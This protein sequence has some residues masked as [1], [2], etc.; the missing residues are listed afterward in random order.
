MDIAAG[1]VGFIG[2]SGQI[3]QGCNYLCKTFSDAADAPDVIVAVSTE[4]CAVRSRLEAFQ[5]LLLEIQASAPACLRVQQD[6]A[7]PL[8]SCQNAIQK[9]QSFVD[10]YADLSISI[11]SS[12]GNVKSY[13]AAFYKAWQKFDVARRG[14]QLRGYVSQLEAAKSSLLAVRSPKRQKISKSVFNVWFGRIELTSSIIKQEDDIDSDY[15][16]P[17]RLQ[18][19][20]TSFRLI[21]NS[22]FLRFGVLFETGQSRPTISHPGWDNRLRVIRTHQGDSLVYNIIRRADYVGFRQLLESREVTPFDLVDSKDLFKGSLFEAVIRQFGIED[23]K[24]NPVMRRDWLNIAKLLAD[25]GVD[26]GVG[27]SLF[28]IMFALALSLDEVT[29]SLFRIIMAQSQTDPFEDSGEA[30]AKNLFVMVRHSQLSPLIKQDEWDL[31]EF[32]KLFDDYGGNGSFQFM[33]RTEGNTRKWGERQ[34]Q[35]WRRMPVSLRRSRSYCVAVFGSHFIKVLWPKLYWSDG[36]PAF[37]QSRQACEEFFGERFVDYEWPKLYCEEEIPSFWRS[38]EACLEAFGEPFVNWDWPEMYW[39]QELPTFWHSRKACLEIFGEI[40]IKYNWPTCL[41]KTCFEFLEGKGAFGQPGM[42]ICKGTNGNIWI[43][44]MV[45]CWSKDDIPQRHLRQYCIDQ[46][47][48]NFVREELP[49]LLRRDGLPEE[50]VVRLTEDGPDME[51]PPPLPYWE[52]EDKSGLEYEES[53]DSQDEHDADSDA[54]SRGESDDEV[55]DGDSDDEL[56]DGW[57]GSIPIGG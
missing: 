14:D 36:K 28:W 3:L 41:G 53:E 43:T 10:K 54:G 55:S 18:A 24:E 5:H 9:V 22:W 26:C 32:T 56:S 47:G 49:S 19:R 30:I 35:K 15:I 13:K 42:W 31:S 46:Y 6:P 37:W 50:E 20:Q 2:L 45:E 11:A 34:K 57:H 1:V 51:P 48:V 33:V 8:Q 4:L 7:V 29:L 39:K 23:N 21:L 12:S 25:S 40:F 17:T 52:Y 38:R 44:Q 16:P 27:G